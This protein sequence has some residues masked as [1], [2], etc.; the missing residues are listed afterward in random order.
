MPT[1]KLMMRSLP[2][3]ET[4]LHT[5]RVSDLESRNYRSLNLSCQAP[6]SFFLFLKEWF[7]WGAGKKSVLMRFLSILCTWSVSKE[8]VRTNF[9]SP[10]FSPP[11]MLLG[12]KLGHFRTGLLIN[13]VFQAIPENST[14]PH[15]KLLSRW[16]TAKVQRLHPNWYS[17]FQNKKTET[18]QSNWIFCVP[19]AV[20]FLTGFNTK[21]FHKWK[22]VILSAAF[23]H[24]LWEGN[25]KEPP[26]AH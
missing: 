11:F 19:K 24:R 26:G 16:K 1:C 4:I 20:L 25:I 5:S 3:W 15:P 18:L 8:H 10:F 17:V 6:K 14:Q 2:I 21:Y 12:I 9:F 7:G 23:T 22:C 13:V